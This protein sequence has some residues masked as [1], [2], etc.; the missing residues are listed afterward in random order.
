MPTASPPPR[1]S[2][3][4]ATATYCSSP[5]RAKWTRTPRRK[6]VTPH[7]RSGT[8]AGPQ[9]PQ[10]TH[11]RRPCGAD[12]RQPQPRGHH[13]EALPLQVPLP[14][15]RV[16]PLEH[17]ELAQEIKEMMGVA[18]S[19]SRKERLDRRKQ[20]F[21]SSRAE[22]MSSQMAPEDVLAKRRIRVVKMD[23]LAQGGGIKGVV[24]LGG[25]PI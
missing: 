7:L 17:R 21:E 19:Y 20:M 2:S 10:Q 11:R 22:K 15:R 14:P 23:S 25:M 12:V 18:D 1:R 5:T 3:A 16:D 6:S 24:D 8:A 9:A 4:T 13:A